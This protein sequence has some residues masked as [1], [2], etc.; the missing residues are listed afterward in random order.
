[1]VNGP[2]TH[3]FPWY[4]TVLKSRLLHMHIKHLTTEMGFCS[5]R[6][7]TDPVQIPIS[8]HSLLVL[9]EPC[10]ASVSLPG[11]CD[12][13]A[14]SPLPPLPRLAP[15]SPLCLYWHWSNFMKL[16]TS[17]AFCFVSVP[18]WH[19]CC[20]RLIRM[21]SIYLSLKLR[22]AKWWVTEYSYQAF[23]SGSVGEGRL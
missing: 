10:A 23:S 7:Y 9:S 12:A 22:V 14:Y 6:P 8:L 17:P 21:Q 4:T 3:C 18:T 1:M 20:F 5:G 13:L 16:S 15:P 11:W 19:V 2:H